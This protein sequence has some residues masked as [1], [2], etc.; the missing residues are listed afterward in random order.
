MALGWT[1]PR[2]WATSELVTSAIMNTHVRDNQLALA[3]AAVVYARDVTSQAVTN[4]TTETTVFTTT[5]AAGDLSTNR[6]LRLTVIADYLNNTGG[7]ESFTVRV[8]YGGTTFAA[9]SHTVAVDA[10]R[11]GMRVDFIISAGNSASVQYAAASMDVGAANTAGGVGSTTAAGSRVTS[12]HNAGAVDSTSSQTFAV[13]FQ[14]GNTG[15]NL[16][17]T[18][19]SAVLELMGVG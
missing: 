16:S 9:L 11:R 14:H 13:T 8:K 1:S 2:T 19:L 5:I 17:A 3:T 10:N 18:C 7:Q 4:T 12:A 6:Q 15:A